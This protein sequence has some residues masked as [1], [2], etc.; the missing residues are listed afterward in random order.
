MGSIILLM[1][2]N[3]KLETDAKNKLKLY[4]E[5]TESSIEEIKAYKHDQKNVLATLK[6][7]IDTEN[8]DSLKTYFYTQ[9]YNDI[10]D[11]NNK[12]FLELSKVKNLPLKGLLISKLTRAKNHNVHVDLMISN[13]VTDLIMKEID[14]C[15]VFGILF[16]NAI[17][18][19]SKTSEKRISLGIMSS[20]NNIYYILSNSLISIPDC[21]KIFE[22][23]ISSKGKNRGIG[24]YNVKKIISRYKGCSINTFIDNNIFFQEIE[25]NYII[26]DQT[27]FVNNFKNKIFINNIKTNKIS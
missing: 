9:I 17:E 3:I 26:K 16:D 14:F 20:T 12:E 10:P 8:I 4:S 13:N 24:L 2:R 7:F 6:E 11:V 15:R 18:E 25:C 27:S 1:L 5:I 19:A 21:T 23:N 22:K